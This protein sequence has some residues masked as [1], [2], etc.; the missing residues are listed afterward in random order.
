MSYQGRVVFGGY[1]G[2]NMPFVGSGL[3]SKSDSNRA[4]EV[5]GDQVR[6]VPTIEP[7][8]SPLEIAKARSN[9]YPA[10]HGFF[11]TDHRP[12]MVCTNG[13]MTKRVKGL[14]EERLPPEHALIDTFKSYKPKKGDP[15]LGIVARGGENAGF[16]AAVCDRTGGFYF[17]VQELKPEPSQIKYVALTGCRDVQ[18]VEISPEATIE[19]LAKEAFSKIFGDD[20]HAIA[21]AAM[22]LAADMGFVSRIYQPEKRE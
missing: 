19:T 13:T 1:L 14:I 6:V 8:Q 21:T 12:V 4:L 10:I 22:V 3:S 17:D 11:D 7:G 20:P 15:R 5:S 16:W 9:I 2:A 18:S